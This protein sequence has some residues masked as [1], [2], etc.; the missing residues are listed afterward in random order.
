[1]NLDVLL[2]LE[3]LRPGEWADVAEVTGEASWVTRLAELGVRAGCRLCL[4]RAGCPCLLQIGGCRLSLRGEQA[5]RI[6]VR[7]VAC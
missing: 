4:L 7:P 1:M 3:F 6:L 5:A 2:P